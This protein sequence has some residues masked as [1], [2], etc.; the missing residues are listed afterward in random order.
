MATIWLTFRV[1]QGT[2]G[3]RSDDERRE[4]IYQA[5]REV[6]ARTWWIEPTS[7][8]LFDSE[9]AV[10]AI[11]Q[12]VR[13]AVAEDDDIVLIRNAEHKTARV[14]GPAEPDLWK[15]MPYVERV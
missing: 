15:L 8:I 5:V 3:G 11:A 12:H 10:E 6:A 2:I 13:E 14:I 9:V 7:F 1:A 4:A